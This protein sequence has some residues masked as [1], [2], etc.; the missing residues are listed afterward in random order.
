[1]VVRGVHELSIAELRA[2]CC[3]RVKSAGASLSDLSAKGVEFAV[4]SKLLQLHFCSEFPAGTFNLLPFWKGTV[5]AFEQPDT[6]PTN[7]P[8]ALFVAWKQAFGVDVPTNNMRMQQMAQAKRMLKSRDIEYWNRII[9]L[10][11]L[12]PFWKK[13]CRNS[14]TTLEKAAQSLSEKSGGKFEQIFGT[15]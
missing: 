9:A 13:S 3:M 4:V 6:K 15:K 5:V 10:A 7:A 14:I 12:D 8:Y 11:V 1:M 2:L